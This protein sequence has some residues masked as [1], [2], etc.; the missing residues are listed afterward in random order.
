[1]VLAI[2]LESLPGV[3]GQEN[4]NEHN[5]SHCNQG[6]GLLRLYIASLTPLLVITYSMKKA[7]KLV[8]VFYAFF[9]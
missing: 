8:T 2:G 6:E 7:C 5:R 4:N 3:Y 9:W 1:M